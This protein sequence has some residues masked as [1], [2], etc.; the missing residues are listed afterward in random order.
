M[1]SGATI[2]F[3]FL[4][5][6]ALSGLGVFLGLYIKKY[7]DDKTK[8]TQLTAVSAALATASATLASTQLQLTAAN[9]NLTACNTRCPPTP[10]T[11]GT[12]N[13]SYRAFYY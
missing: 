8:T 7:S 5:L 11:G 2:L 6:L 9:T 1:A 4:F 13:S 12:T 10:P 3:I